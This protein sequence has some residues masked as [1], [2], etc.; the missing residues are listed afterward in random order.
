MLFYYLIFFIIISFYIYNKSTDLNEGNDIKVYLFAG[1]QLLNNAN[2]YQNNPYN[3]YLYSPLFALLISPISLINWTISR[4]IWSTINIILIFRIWNI[5]KNLTLFSFGLITKYKTFNLIL[6]SIISIGIINLNLSLGQV[7]ILILWLTLEGVMFILN[8]KY[9]TGSILISLGINFKLLPLIVIYY[10]ILKGKFKA[11]F[12]IILLSLLFIILPGFIIGMKYNT[13][14]HIKW[15]N[16]INPTQPKYVF[17]YDNANQ[18]LN[19][20]LPAYFNDQSLEKAKIDNSKYIGNREIIN[21][22]YNT[23]F[24]ILQILR[25]VILLSL[26][27]LILYKKYYKYKENL[28]LYNFWEFSYLMLI[29]LL[30]FPHQ[31]NYSMIYFIPTCTY[32]CFYFLLIFN[33]KLKLT[34]MEKFSGIFGAFLILICSIR[35]RDIIGNYMVDLIDFYHVTGITNIIFLVILIINNPNR[36]QNKF[37]KLNN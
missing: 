11:I 8:N 3:Q 1:K 24:G 6:L 27:P 33:Y 29:T 19:A 9:F 30:I 2:I 14:L 21:V 17:E 5:F 26:I 37:I 31:S 16:T 28:L 22:N 4:L 15:I 36:L 20:I 12:Y 23:L 25:V 32:N 10:L 34:V 7:T 35:G 13:Q 18:S